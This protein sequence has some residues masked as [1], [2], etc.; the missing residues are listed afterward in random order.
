[1]PD[2]IS[3]ARDR[4]EASLLGLALGDAMGMPSQTLSMAEI[5]ARHGWIADLVAPAPDHPVSRG[6]VAG[7][8]TDDTEQSLLLARRLI[9]G[10]GQIAP[11]DW[12][13][14]LL[15][16][17]ADVRARGLHDLLGPSTKAALAALL[18]GADPATSGQGGTTNGAAMRILPVAIATPP[19]PLSRLIDAVEAACR[20]TH[21]TGE[22]IA[23][24]AAVAA[25]ASAG[26]EGADFQTTLPLALAAARAGEA[27]GTPTGACDI[28]GRIAA[29][30]EL[31]G[32]GVT[33]SE[34]AQ[35]TGTLVA[36]HQSVPA[37]FGVLSLAGGEVTRATE[38][39]ANIGGDTDTIGAISGGMGGATT[40]C[41]AL[42]EARIARLR[43][44]NQLDLAPLV[45]GLIRLRLKGAT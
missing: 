38:L 42:P 35:A 7:Q 14:D 11:M 26:L 19:E 24:A 32:R 37:A 23:G 30:L 10:N 43:A 6:L 2:T 40:G 13:D 3:L 20:I 33:L 28:A 16:W 17:E 5:A 27:R 21:N 22:A 15:G 44:V 45:E 4:A 41:T 18:A 36:T 9:A 1:M 39:A 25:V 34:L 8:V 12:A 29:A 31:A